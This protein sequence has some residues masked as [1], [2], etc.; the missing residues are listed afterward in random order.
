[1]IKD[2]RPS[3]ALRLLGVDIKPTELSKL[4]IRNTQFGLVST[5]KMS[6]KHMERVVCF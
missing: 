2:I 4:Q 1:M 3:I 6:I 5:I